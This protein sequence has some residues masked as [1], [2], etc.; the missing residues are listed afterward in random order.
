MAK[1]VK[2]KLA[3]LFLDL[4]NPR[5]EEQANQADALNTIATAQGDK[6]LALLRDIIEHGLNPS[7]MLIVAPMEEERGRGKN[8]YVVLEGN[9]RVAAMKLLRNPS[10][11]RDDKLKAKYAKLHDKHKNDPKVPKQIECV[12][13][14]PEVARLWIERK[15]E[16]ELG[17]IGVVQWDSVQKDRFQ[18]K[19]SGKDSKVL[20]LIDFMKGLSGNDEAFHAQIDKIGPTNF[21]RLF[22]TPEVRYKLGL[23]IQKGMFVA[24]H[25]PDEIMRGLRSVVQHMAK[26]SFTV[27]EI[28]YKDDRLKFIAKVSKDG[29]LPDETKRSE[30]TWV[31]REYQ[32]RQQNS[33]GTDTD[34][35]KQQGEQGSKDKGLQNQEGGKDNSEQRP[36]NRETLI[37]EDLTLTIPNERINRLFVEMKSLVLNE[38][39]NICAVMLRVFVEWSIDAFLETYEVKGEKKLNVDI[40]RGIK[41]KFTDVV[42]KM[43]TLHCINPDHLKGI[44]TAFS[45]DRESIFSFHT[46]N[47]Y[48]HNN[49][50]NPIPTEIMYSWDNAE[51]FIKALWKAVNDKL[52]KNKQK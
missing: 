18:N 1:N 34:K 13:L 22:S 46:L 8:S 30:K 5:Y 31:L 6:L 42:E 25:E 49:T 39:P 2:L 26:D 33:G 21:Q 15:H 10:I 47:A 9:R 27:D 16:G 20:Q 29:E 12:V 17:G 52:N 14:K 50:F 19:N 4:G 28:Y 41:G 7:E 3:N 51:P 45:E 32:S 38:S 37:P 44:E 43:K 35:D 11:L 48:V 23:D 40:N 24:Y 36:T